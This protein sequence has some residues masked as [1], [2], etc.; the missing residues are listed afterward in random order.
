MR[1]EGGEGEGAGGGDDDAAA[2]GNA[3]SPPP[4]SPSSTPSPLDQ[5]WLL[6]LWEP[7]TEDSGA[8]PLPKEGQ[9]VWVTSLTP[10]PRWRN[11]PL[12][13][14]RPQLSGGRATAW[15]LWRQPR[16]EPPLAFECPARRSVD[17]SG[18][19]SL[20]RGGDFDFEGVLIAAGPVRAEGVVVSS[21]LAS[22]PVPPLFS[23][24]RDADASSSSLRP[25][26]AEQWLF[27]ADAAALALMESG[28][29]PDEVWLLAVRVS[30]PLAAAPFLFPLTKRSSSR[31][32]A[33]GVSGGNN[34]ST[35]S[36]SSSSFSS[37]AGLPVRI[38]DAR[39]ALAPD[40]RERLWRAEARDTAV[41]A[42]VGAG[43]S[44]RGGNRGGRDGGDGSSLGARAVAAFGSRV[45]ALLGS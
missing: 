9:V 14:S 4:P 44:A 37:L 12:A 39:L 25:P 16:S 23:D 17:L 21:A 31:S 6:Q 24:H 22:V 8:P 36:S 30:G 42:L 7:P 38:R 34:G 19:S 43:G 1:R 20:P 3:P 10:R 33:S 13:L 41:V 28:V 32:G 2:D 15:G 45:A 27:C 40:D 26:D 5:E 18:L 29:P 35:S 11:D